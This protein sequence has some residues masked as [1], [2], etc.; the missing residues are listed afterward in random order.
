LPSEILENLGADFTFCLYNQKEGK[1]LVLVAKI[2]EKE[3]LESA[4]PNLEKKIEKEGFAFFGEKMM[5]IVKSFRTQV[6]LGEKV[7]YLTF[8]KNDLGFCYT[9]VKD[10][11]IFTTS[12]GSMTKVL[13]NLKI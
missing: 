11:F 3:K 7:R 2:K 13:P 10:S 1:R 6:I 8:A 12:L 4:L 9:L 5:P